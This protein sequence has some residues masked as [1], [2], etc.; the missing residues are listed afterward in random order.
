MR[1]V[2]PFITLLVYRIVLFALL[3]LILVV[4][5]FR[6]K[7]NA[8]YR[9]RLLERLGFIDPKLQA[10][11]IVVHAA[12]VG[13]VIALKP[14]IEKLLTVYPDKP[15]TLT[16]FTPTGS[17][18]VKKLFND[19]VQHCYLS[20]DIWPCTILFLARL[21]PQAVVLME[22]ELWPNFIAQC[23]NK[24]IKLLLIN[25]RLSSKSLPSYQK[26]S[27]LIAPCLQNFTQILTQSEEHRSNF[28]SLG[29]KPENCSTSGNVKYDIAIT[30]E[31]L[32][33]Q[34]MLSA[35]IGNESEDKGEDNRE[36]INDSKRQVWLVAS[37]H[38]NDENIILKAFKLLKVLHPKL[39]LIL[40]PRHPERFDAVY[41]LCIHAEFNT[42]RR[43]EKTQITW[44]DD[45]WLLDS[46]GELLPSC[47][48]AD[49]VTMGGSFSSIGGHNPLEPALFK[50][51]IVVGPD[52][53]NFAEVMQQLEQQQAII[54]LEQSNEMDAE[55]ADT[56]GNLL[57]Q[58]ELQQQLGENAFA[59]VQTNQGA[60][61]RSAETLQSIIRNEHS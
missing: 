61:Q 38:P 57:T 7:N 14:F 32:A 55:L 35:F 44:S 40:V 19:R 24:G 30:E 1:V 60:S 4:L 28:I 42:I 31:L 21:K 56:I 37:T 26:L 6:S 25:G 53:R 27:W 8:A 13:E 51:A 23:A 52:M 2:R 47:A 9:Q 59:V 43:S 41:Q 18:Q 15:I 12:S 36:N 20:L 17:A 46:L 34:A 16:T 54:Q 48:L 49:I 58:A 11:G 29:A 39:L 22:T 33:K 5:L 10:N 3:P 45:I 50:K